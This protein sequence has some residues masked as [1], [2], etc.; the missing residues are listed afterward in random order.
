MRPSEPRKTGRTLLV[1]LSR[2][3]P[4]L[5][6]AAV[7]VLLVTAASPT[8]VQAKS[9]T[10][11]SGAAKVPN[12]QAAL[13]SNLTLGEAEWASEYSQAAA[14]R[15]VR[16]QSPS[17]FYARQRSQLAYRHLSAIEAV[18]L[19][20]SQFSWFV[21]RPAGGPPHVRGT[22][23]LSYTGREVAQV[24]LPDHHRGL[25]ASAAPIAVSVGKRRYAPV[26]L[27]LRSAARAFLPARPAVAVEIPRRLA[28]GAKLDPVGVTLTPVD[29][30]G[31]A[32][33]TASG[34]RLDGAGVIYPNALPDAD[35]II[36]PTTL[37][38]S[39]DTLIRSIYSPRHLYFRVGMPKHATLVRTSGGQF[40]VRQNATTLATIAPPLAVDAEGQ[41]VP[42]SLNA[43]GARLQVSVG[44]LEGHP[45]PILVDP[46]IRDSVL[47]TT[48]TKGTPP[49][50]R[51]TNWTFVPKGSAFKGTDT[52]EGGWHLEFGSHHQDERGSL[53]YTTRGESQIVKA[54]VEGSWNVELA[55]VRNV[56]VLN[57]PSK[58]VNGQGVPP[59]EVE[60]YSNLPRKTT[61][62]ES[63]GEVCAPALK[64]AGTELPSTPAPPLD[65]N[66]VEFRQ[67]GTETTT[68][69]PTNT[70]ILSNAYVTIEQAAEPK[71][72][73]NIESPTITNPATGQTVTNVLY[74][75]AESWFGPHNGAFEVRASDPG[76]GIKEYSLLGGGVYDY[77]PFSAGYPVGCYGL[78][79]IS[80][81]SLQKPACYGVQCPV[82]V[83]QAYIYNTNMPD[84]NDSTTAFVENMIGKY[85]ALRN[86]PIKVDSTPPPREDIKIGGFENGDE[87]PLGEPHINVQAADG[88]GERSS[89]GIQSI[90]VTVDGKPV[91]GT[92]ASCQTP[93]GPCT[94]T[95]EVTLASRMYSP[96]EHSTVITATD[97]ANNVTR[98]EFKFRVH[99]ATPIGAGP[100]TLDPTTGE[101]TFTSADV[102]LGAATV[103][104]AYRS[105]HLDAGEEGPLGHQWTLDVG[106]GEGI[107]I[108]PNGDA[109]MTG[110]GGARTT[111]VP[112]GERAFASPP[113]D[114]SL[115]LTAEEPVP[116]QGIRALVLSDSASGTST[117]FEQPA[118]ALETA[119]VPAAHF[120]NEV[121]E[122]D[123]P[124]G[125]ATDASGHVW[126][127]SAASDTVA[128]YSAGGVLEASYGS[129]GPSG[130]QFNE[131]AGIAVD[132]T[133]D[134]YV[135]DKKNNRIEE[136]SATGAF[137]KTFG[138]GVTNG[139]PEFEVCTSECKPGQPGNAA[140]QMNEPAGVAVDGTGNIWVA[141][142]GNSRIQEIS[143]EGTSPRTIGTGQ[144]SGPLGVIVAEGKVYVADT[145]N[146]RVAVFST[147]GT[148]ETSIGKAGTENNQFSHPAGIVFDPLTRDLYVTDTGNHR[149]QQ[150]SLGGQ[151]VSS[152]MTEANGTSI[153][154]P[155]G[156]AVSSN[157]SVFV[158][159][160]TANEVG[161]WTRPTWVPREA[162]GPLSGIATTYAYQSVKV[163]GHSVTEPTEVLAPKPAKVSCEPELQRGCRAL[164]FEYATKTTVNETE[165]GDTANRSE[166]GEYEGRL[167]RIYL[168]AWNP[169]T[170]AMAKIAVAEYAYDTYGRL[171]EEWDPRTE[172]AKDCTTLETKACEA[173]KTVYGYSEDG[174]A[175]APLTA[176]TSPG[177]ES[178]ALIYDVPGALGS[179]LRLRKITTGELTTG[180]R[181][182]A[183]WD[184][185]ALQ[186][187][188]KPT[189]SGLPV[190]GSNLTAN[191]GNWE[192]SPVAYTYQWHRCT[193]KE[194]SCKGIPG[195]TNN[196]YTPQATDVGD[197]LELF[198]TALNASGELTKKSTTYGPI[199]ATG[200]KTMAE[201]PAMEPG[202][203]IEYG[204]PT[205]GPGLPDLSKEAVSAWGQTKDLPVEGVAVFPSSHPETWPA[206]G[207]ASA[208]IDYW[209]KQG[210]MVNAETPGGGIATTEY[211][212]SNEV[213]RTLSAKNRET[214]LAAKSV[215]LATLLS[216][217][218][219]YTGET[220]AERAQEEKEVSER[221]K[222]A[223][224]PGAEL[225]ETRGPQHPVKLAETGSVVQAR[226]HTVYS[227]DEGAPKGEGE[228]LLTKTRDG[229]EYEGKE[230]DVRTTTT[231]YGGQEGLG[232]VLRKPTATTVDPSGLDLKT[233]T[234]YD[235]TTGDITETTSPAGTTQSPVPAYAYTFGQQGAGTGQFEAPAAVAISPKTGNVYVADAKKDTVEEFSSSGEW[236]ARLGEP[237]KIAKPEALAIDGSG[238]IWVAESGAERLEEFNSHGTP[239]RT[240]GEKGSAAGQ[241]GG[242]IAGIAI[243][244]KDLWVSDEANRR[245]EEFTE[246]GK[247][248]QSIGPFPAGSDF[249][250]PAGVATQAN[251][252]YVA[253]PTN[254]RVV[255]YEVKHK[256]KRETDFGTIGPHSETMNEP[257]GITTEPEKLGLGVYV[258]DRAAGRIDEFTAGGRFVA[259]IGHSG[260]ENGQLNSPIAAASDAA[261][262]LY[263][264]DA[265]NDRVSVWDSPDGGTHT[266]R[267]VYYSTAEN[268][269]HHECGGHQEWANLPCETLPGNQPR[270]GTLPKL[271]EIRTTYNL[272]DQAE[273]I[274]ETFGTRTRTK[275][276]TYDPVG[277]AVTSEITEE[278]RH[279]HTSHDA[280]LPQVTNQYNPTSG[281]LETQS[282]SVGGTTKTITEKANTLG[283]LEH[284]TDAQGVTTT[285]EYE[286]WGR[287]QG[288]NYGTVDGIAASQTYIYNQTTGA[289]EG[290][291][292]SNV[293]EFKA[294]Y[295][296]GGNLKSQSYPNGMTASYERNSLNEA[297]GVEYAK[298]ASC[299]SSC[300]LFHETDVPSSHGELATQESTLANTQ[301][302]YDTLGRLLTVT[303]EPAGKSCKTTRRYS[304]DEEGDRSNLSTATAGPT[305][306]CGAEATNEEPHA[307]DV[308]N[309]LDDSGV[310]YEA[311]G[312]I[313]NLPKRDANHEEV[314]TSYYVDGQVSTQEQENKHITYGYDP[315]GRTT[316][317]AVAGGSMRT[318]DYAG[319]GEAVTWAT[320]AANIYER[321]VPGIDGTLTATEKSGQET[322]LQLH[323]LRGDTVASV[324]RTEAGMS[325]KSLY[326]P[327]EFGVPQPNSKSPTYGWLGATGLRSELPT[328]GV[329]TTSETSY[330]PEIGRALQSG[331]VASPGAFP[332]GSGGA[333]SVGA[334]VLGA[335]SGELKQIEVQDEAEFEAIKQHEAEER[336]ALEAYEAEGTCEKN[337]G[338]CPPGPGHGNCEVNCVI[339]ESGGGGDPF[340]VLTGKEALSLGLKYLQ[341][342]VGY[343]LEGAS[344]AKYGN[345]P[346]VVRSEVLK[347]FY[348]GASEKL[349]GCYEKVH[350]GRKSAGG[351]Y[352]NGVCWIS[353]IV[354]NGGY[355]TELE[356]EPCWSGRRYGL[357]EW[358]CQEH[359]WRQLRQ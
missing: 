168:N 299:T 306:E 314:K 253:D 74:K 102:S 194:T 135:A 238:N 234:V 139:K 93:K 36:K 72:E 272:W 342:A 29:A 271:P 275:T 284:Y 183:P 60:A 245:V 294:T 14:A 274:K 73:F 233:T 48:M 249:W 55:G 195:A 98:E 321:D 101:F 205:S 181:I 288:I 38:L 222:P 350:N 70:T 26:D 357:N 301:N 307:Y 114:S 200:E 147:G 290:L 22:Q 282:A 104:R 347:D 1:A 214:A 302:T 267:Y 324:G 5:I 339:T 43:T 180:G 354:S 276:Q 273:T 124:I 230:A 246:S 260:S 344:C 59:D 78:E 159:G 191:T 153:N 150:I 322:V 34:G 81:P 140:G 334:P 15:E 287:L 247:Y 172:Q 298:G 94:A 197:Y 132:H 192:N 67:E 120:G 69:A 329:T 133:G 108:E 87:L 252:L 80:K 255:I 31:R 44:Q 118:D 297:V 138:W 20:R 143:S 289:R 223:A 56:L 162:G 165:E 126:V 261:G 218:R 121:G 211:N 333:G 47:D 62:Y 240:I 206:R 17:A 106:G 52:G 285:Y 32:L 110:G 248:K 256:P 86:Q 309:R 323:D 356:V 185:R 142:T 99:G 76:M 123:S 149:V 82:Y 216:T 348:G 308:A 154:A 41:E 45:L 65:N 178:T 283:E 134:V 341:Q 346:C 265:G 151:F 115:K 291:T 79:C 315:A 270:G 227:Y 345:T 107:H 160:P 340:K 220:S 280:Q 42:V 359:G 203:T 328:S 312:N 188:S 136:L 338:E 39:V 89:S 63:G 10:P 129:Y 279:E 145:Q 325:L 158:T 50:P 24:M 71:L 127:S 355:P 241:F 295:D 96:G 169:A 157:G 209:D 242:A 277:R 61:N 251:K 156:I 13:G 310:A 352:E 326:T 117:R 300:T 176:I 258:S 264:A 179:E 53:V 111:F 177:H 358:Y 217:V 40:A 210:R 166:W 28:A 23:I 11:H 278:E 30:G 27:H 112:S 316:T 148:L 51:P 128:R 75:S 293:G 3:V 144:L 313:T 66:S 193:A 266:Q 18:N 2:Q 92:P 77:R 109:V 163:A 6:A 152:F 286:P 349:K 85:R 12:S 49:E 262:N 37:G 337:P 353:W 19:S 318:L 9:E 254:H 296:S 198:V 119:P 35:A 236:V 311:Y 327:T 58:F 16:R 196:Y 317:V 232:W 229:A 105:Q 207:Y 226:D 343:G 239:V 175:E 259:T 146:N 57:A 202:I 190:V 83:N 268:A 213:T 116:A 64:C 100:G 330:V 319:P 237:G 225:L 173:L 125:A 228:Y 263:I 95:T 332:D 130:G 4:A 84:G 186:N 174:E 303:E 97:N 141:D 171:R 351:E 33:R 164:T 331:P 257:I 215:I 131:P 103:S 250:T 189:I 137:V 184:G 201:P 155:T 199:T 336:A 46:E 243:A 305:N 231:E 54:G 91:S 224:V 25:L 167:S 161:E 212:E 244:G 187:T 21:N 281:A 90:T 170:Q 320:E 335:S 269:Q 292:D 304:Y 219:R 235:K 122:L 182:N 8:S 7:A 221:H 68:G 204:I 88:E 113:G 208:T